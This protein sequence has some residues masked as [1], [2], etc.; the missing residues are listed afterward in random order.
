MSDEENDIIINSCECGAK[1]EVSASEAGQV[2]TCGACGRD[3][4]VTLPEALRASQAPAVAERQWYYAKDNRQIGPVSESGMHELFKAGTIGGGTLVW[5]ESLQ[6]WAYASSFEVFQAYGLTLP[7]AK[8]KSGMRVVLIAA[9]VP[10][11]LVIVII[12]ILAAIL[13]PVLADA[14][15]SA[16]RS[17][18]SNNLRQMG[19]VMQIY[20]AENKGRFP[21]IDNVKGNFIF[22]GDQIYPEYLTDVDVLGCPSDLGYYQGRTFRLKDNEQHPGF[23]VGAPH[24]DSVTA[25]SYVYLGWAATSEEEGLAALGA[26]R[27]ASE[28]ELDMDLSVPEG[29]GN[30]GGALIFRLN[31]NIERRIINATP[32]DSLRRDRSKIRDIA[33]AT[34]GYNSLPIMW[35]WPSSHIPEGANVLYLDGRVEFIRYPDRFPMTE[36]FVEEL[37]SFEPNL[38]PDVEPIADR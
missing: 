21:R 23:S 36:A 34:R 7:S 14:R 19:L 32:Q 13:L 33:R 11:I 20:A 4:V 31:E 2:V 25:E 22:E 8:Q 17:A 29:E 9:G 18:C 12:G 3:M 26:Y 28:S 10:T 16:R 24:A 37:R 38:S 1:L 6:D 15:E 30:G 35:E 5:T 27:R